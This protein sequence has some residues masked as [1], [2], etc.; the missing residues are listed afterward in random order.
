MTHNVSA[1]DLRSMC[2]GAAG[3]LQRYGWW[4]GGVGDK[5][6]GFC[7]I[8]ALDEYFNMHDTEYGTRN[9]A[10]EYLE[11]LVGERPLHRWNDSKGS[12]EEAIDYL[13]RAAETAER[14][15]ERLKGYSW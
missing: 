1:D 6:T 4:V 3:L 9:V 12:R 10:V 7:I 11:Q 8:G 2:T 5:N 14:G 13:M 15:V